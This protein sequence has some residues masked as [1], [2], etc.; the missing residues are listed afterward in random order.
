MEHKI[1]EF[2]KLIDFSAYSNLVYHFALVLY[3][4]IEY[5]NS[6]ALQLK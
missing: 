4:S 5:V 1:L 2:I 3:Y 6:I